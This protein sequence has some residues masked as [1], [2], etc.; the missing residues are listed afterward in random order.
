MGGWVDGGQEGE[1]EER[2]PGQQPV[3]AS[4]PSKAGHLTRAL[5]APPASPLP[6]CCSVPRQQAAADD[7]TTDYLGTAVER[8]QQLR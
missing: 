5:P 2:G 6:Y 8:V 7:V 1:A 4:F 3:E